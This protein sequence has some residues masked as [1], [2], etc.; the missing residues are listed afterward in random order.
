MVSNDAQDIRNKLQL[1]ALLNSEVAL[2]WVL[3]PPHTYLFL[4]F[5][6]QNVRVQSV[7][8]GRSLMRRF[9]I[10]AYLCT[11]VKDVRV[12]GVQVWVLWLEQRKLWESITWAR[13]V[14]LGRNKVQ[15]HGQ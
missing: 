6:G 7:L 3:H 15:T 2:P 1:F 11:T 5:G 12:M 14:R 13:M 9:Q 8:N 4:H 10:C